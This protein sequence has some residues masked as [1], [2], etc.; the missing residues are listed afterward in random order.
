MG[1]SKISSYLIRFLNENFFKHR[2]YEGKSLFSFSE[3]LSTGAKAEINIDGKTMESTRAAKEAS[4][5]G[6]A[7]RFTFDLAADHVYKLLL[8]N[9]CYPRYIRSD[10]YKTLLSNALDPGKKKKA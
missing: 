6:T 4:M 8:K 3:F 5:K 7:S 2:L 10:S 1:V 9:D